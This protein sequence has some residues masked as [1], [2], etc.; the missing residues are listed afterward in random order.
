YALDPCGNDLI[1]CEDRAFDVIKAIRECRDA[2]RRRRRGDCDPYEPVPDPRCKDVEEH[3]CI[4]IEYDEREARPTTALRPEKKQSC[5][6]GCNGAGRSGGCGCGCHQMNGKSAQAKTWAGQGAEINLGQ[7]E[8][9]RTLEGY[10]LGVIE[11]PEHCRGERKSGDD[12][13]KTPLS[14]L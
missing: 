2:R 4:T 7:C 14:R 13:R 11:A 6:C 12:R 1:V 5:G 3:W 10:R 9:T 8:P